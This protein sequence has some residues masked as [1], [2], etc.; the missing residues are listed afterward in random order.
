MTERTGGDVVVD[1]LARSGVEVVLA[2]RV[3]TISRFTTRSGVTAGFA[4]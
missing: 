3:S 1:V 4:R 2:S